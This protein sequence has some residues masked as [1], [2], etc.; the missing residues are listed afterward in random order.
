M[1]VLEEATF[2]Q[3]GNQ[4]R[5]LVQNN[6]EFPLGESCR[7]L[8]EAHDL[9]KI[10]LANDGED[11]FK[12]LMGKSCKEV[13]LV[14]NDSL[15]TSFPSTSIGDEYWVKEFFLLVLYE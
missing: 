11:E 9:T 5:V 13:R 1:Q 7:S 14:Q 6:Y 12:S 3:E 10:G 15:P 4:T 8:E 2:K